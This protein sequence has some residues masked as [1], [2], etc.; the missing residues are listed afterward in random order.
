MAMKRN[1]TAMEYKSTIRKL[2]AVRPQLSLSSDFIV[3]F[4]GET[5][6]DFARMMK[7]VD[8]VG[9]DASF[10]FIFSPRPGTPAAALQDDTP[11]EV[12]LKRLQHLQAVLEDNVRRISD[13]RVGTVQ[14]ILVEGPS[15]KDPNELMGRTECNRIVNFPGAKRLV[16]E[17]V[18]VTITQAL[19]HSLR[20]EV[21][22]REAA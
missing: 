4:P 22:M 15:R 9:Y 19:P 14:R 17:M 16:G 12:K 10:S 2:R 11:H 18:D 5:E 1:Y 21:L 7:L 13:S 20:A 8:D 3:G 6:Q